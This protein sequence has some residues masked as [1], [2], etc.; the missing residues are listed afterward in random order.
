MVYS[1]ISMIILVIISGVFAAAEIALVIVSDNKVNHDADLGNIR[2]IRIKK[3]TE[4]LFH[5]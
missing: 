3:Y 1:I 2:A 4:N 5:Y